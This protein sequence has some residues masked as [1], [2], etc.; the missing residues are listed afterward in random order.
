MTFT[1]RIG[2]WEATAAREVDAVG[3]GDFDLG[4]VQ[5]ELPPLIVSGIVVDSE[6]EPL[7]D[8]EIRIAGSTTVH[9]AR[10][11]AF[12]LRGPVPEGRL[13]LSARHHDK[14]PLEQS[15]T[16]GAS[17]LELV[18]EQGATLI[19]QVLFDARIGSTLMYLVVNSRVQGPQPREGRTRAEGRLV[20]ID[21]TGRFELGPKPR[22]EYDLSL[23]GRTWLGPRLE[24]EEALLLENGPQSRTYDLREQLCITRVQIT[25][26]DGLD[27]DE[28]GYELETEEQPARA[29]LTSSA[30]S[31]TAADSLHTWVS[32]E[33]T[34][35]IIA[36]PGS[37][38]AR[39][40]LDGRDQRL[41]LPA[42]TI[43]D[44]VVRGAEQL[45]PGMSLGLRLQPPERTD[46]TVL[47]RFENGRVRLALSSGGTWRG[48]VLL[49]RERD[50][51]SFP[52]QSVR[53]QLEDTPGI[54]P[55]TIELDR[56]TLESAE[57]LAR[58]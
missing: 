49:H 14:M 18:L 8:V 6:R 28:V 47:G 11:G 52:A 4:D 23:G 30:R 55:V 19:G 3:P 48:R 31:S 1:T 9:T 10:D 26:I 56:R 44:V 5:L 40:H 32:L 36:A 12:E 37:R 46:P 54:Q 25:N 24:L 39:I 41:Q 16:A 51:R 33:P 45:P 7:E 20:E 53:L 27:L 57:I 38:A 42:G 21:S 2:E 13:L 29:K 34:T 43:V 15:F 22:G 17:G 35:V 58:E 50:D